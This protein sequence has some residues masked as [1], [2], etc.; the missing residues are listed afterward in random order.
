M[1]RV[2]YSFLFS[3]GLSAIAA[4]QPASIFP[5]GEK[6]A[7]V[8]HTGNVWLK[9]LVAADSILDCHVSLATFDADAR[10]DWHRHPG[11]QILMITDGVGYYQEKGKPKQTV[12]KGDIIKCLPDVE[13]WHGATPQSGFAYLAINTNNKKG[14]TIWSQ[15]VTNA[16]YY[17][18]KPPAAQGSDAADE[19]KQLSKDKWQWMADKNADKL[20]TLFHDKS[21]FIHMGGTWGKD[22][23]LDVIKSGG[24][25]YKKAEVYSAEVNIIG[26]TAILLND[27]DLVAVVGGNEVVN[28][29]MVTEVYVKEDG[30]WKM[31][32]LTFSRLMRPVKLK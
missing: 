19:L 6:A 25:H 10:L 29:F 13:H 2:L 24:I 17:G 20:A 21:M 23:E 1:K 14:R 16:D 28:P 11:G 30:N 26:N 22:R 4:G 18:A 15:K 9:E 12:K 3:T 8:H 32:S 5:K 27:I 7:N 31:G